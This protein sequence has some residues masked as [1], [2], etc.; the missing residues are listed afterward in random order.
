MGVFK[1]L[2]WE[3]W[4]CVYA[5]LTER[6]LIR[7]D[8]ESA[9]REKK[10]T[11]MQSRCVC[12][13]NWAERSAARSSRTNGQ[14]SKLKSIKKSAHHIYVCLRGTLRLEK[15]GYYGKESQVVLSLVRDG[16]QKRHEVCCGKVPDGNECK[17]VKQN[18]T[19]KELKC[20]VGLPLACKIWNGTHKSINA[21]RCVLPKRHKCAQG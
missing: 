7:T 4:V 16:R 18:M 8:L 5:C 9:G 10:S 20:S 19:E 14:L 6:W 1:E 21:S 15:W 13:H 12:L 2:W 17:R 3:W 11:N